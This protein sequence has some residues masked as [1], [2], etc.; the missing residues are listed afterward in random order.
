VAVKITIVTSGLSEGGAERSMSILANAWVSNGKQVHVILSCF[1]EPSSNSYLEPAV[2]TTCVIGSRIAKK[3]PPRIKTFGVL[4]ALRRAIGNTRPDVI[5]AFLDS[6]AVDT[7]LATLGTGIP[8]IVA[9]HGDPG[10]RRAGFT[11]GPAGVSG[12]RSR[13]IEALRRGLYPSAASVVCLTETAMSRFPASIRG[14]GRIIPNP[15]LPPP[16]PSVRNPHTYNRRIVYLGRLAPVKGLDRLLRAFAMVAGDHPDWRLEIWGIGEDESRLKRTA[17]DLGIRNRV[18]FA[19]WSDSPHEVF[20]GADLFVMT[21]HTEG[22]PNALCEAMASGVAPV[23]FDCPSGPRHIIRHGVDGILVPDGDV[24][25]LARTMGYLM[26]N[27]PERKRLASRAPEVLERFDAGKV[28]GMW[29][30]LLDE[31]SRGPRGSAFHRQVGA[32]S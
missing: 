12:L 16:V 23:C 24:G 17:A 8:V 19:G 27:E 13:I 15:V 30:D 29:E 1:D 18:E 22:F 20:Q 26:D 6:V 11:E 7:L 25:G 4:L 21:S 14:K 10:G 9:E 2:T 28:L 3:W 5:I 31:V 32:G